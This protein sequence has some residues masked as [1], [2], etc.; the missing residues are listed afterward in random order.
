MPCM[1]TQETIHDVIERFREAPSNGER[2]AK[3]E[4]AFAPDRGHAGV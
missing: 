4:R 2:G 3:F 1:A